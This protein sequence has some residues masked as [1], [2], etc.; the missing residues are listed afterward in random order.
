MAVPLS[1]PGF[2]R[3]EVAGITVNVALL[4]I[5]LPAGFVTFTRKVEPLSNKVVVGVVYDAPVAPGIFEPFFCHWYVNGVVPVATTL[6]VAARPALTVWFNGCVVMLTGVGGINVRVALV[7][8]TLP[9]AFD[10]LTRKVDLLSACMVAG[11]V[12]VAPVAPGMIE[13]FFC[14]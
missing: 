3:I 5:T 14:H 1:K 11:V 4:L 12:Y 10:T 13:P 6:N 9:M 2:L 8:T 7:L